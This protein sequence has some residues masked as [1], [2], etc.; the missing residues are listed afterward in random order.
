MQF[1]KNF[2]PKDD[3]RIIRDTW[4]VNVVAIQ[5]GTQFPNRYVIMS[6]D[7]IPELATQTILLQIPLV[8]MIMHRVW[9]EQLKQQEF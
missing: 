8:Q 7:M 5:K 4:V 1:Q 2:V 9:Q 6:G 3:R